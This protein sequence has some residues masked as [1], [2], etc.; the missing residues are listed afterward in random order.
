MITPQLLLR[1]ALLA[2]MLLLGIGLFYQYHHQP[3]WNTTHTW[4]GTGT[5]TLGRITLTTPWQVIWR[6]QHAT[7]MVG[8]I[9]YEQQRNQ[10]DPLRQTTTVPCTNTPIREKAVGNMPAYLALTTTGTWSVT[11]QLLE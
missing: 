6:C 4:Q 7:S 5:A 2:A 10:A 1:M 11:L 8:Q 9:D 3:T